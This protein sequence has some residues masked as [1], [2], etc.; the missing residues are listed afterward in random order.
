MPV[1]EFSADVPAWAKRVASAIY[2]ARLRAGLTQAGLAQRAGVRQA[3]VSQAEND[4]SAMRLA[5][6]E[7]ILSALQL[8][9]TPVQA[10]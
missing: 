3:T 1:R 2:V 10:L 8:T 9:L 4:P 5:T 7:R 6:L